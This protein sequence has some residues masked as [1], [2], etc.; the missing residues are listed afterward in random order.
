MHTLGVGEHVLGGGQFLV[1]SRH[2]PDLLD[3]AQLK[4]NQLESRRLFPAV[5][6]RPLQLVTQLAEA[7]PRDGD[8]IRD[9]RELR[10]AV[11]E[12]KV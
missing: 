4:R 5:H 10:V 3:L 1:L 9:C 8:A 12:R 6:P 11:E 2:R 7:T